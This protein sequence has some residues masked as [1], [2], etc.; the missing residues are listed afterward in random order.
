MIECYVCFSLGEFTRYICEVGRP[1]EWVQRVAGLEFLR[2][3]PEDEVS[4]RVEAAI[5]ASCM[6]ETI[7]RLRARV[8]ARQALQKQLASLG[9]S[10]LILWVKVSCFCSMTLG[11]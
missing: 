5:S 8:R 6:E 7:K 11:K 9:Q 2:V 10:I 1:Y 3:Q 4:S